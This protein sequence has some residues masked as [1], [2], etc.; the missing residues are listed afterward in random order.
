MVLLL[1]LL[2]PGSRIRTLALVV[3]SA[4]CVSS[5]ILLPLRTSLW[6][7][8]AFVRH[9]EQRRRCRCVSADGWY[10][11]LRSRHD[12]GCLLRRSGGYR[13]ADL[14]S[15]LAR[16]GEISAL[17][18]GGCAAEFR[19]EY[20]ADRACAEHDDLLVLSSGNRRLVRD[21]RICGR[22]AHPDCP[23]DWRSFACP[24]DYA[25]VARETPVLAHWA[26]RDPVSMERAMRAVI[27]PESLVYGP[28]AQYFLSV[29]C[30]WR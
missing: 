8:V 12:I 21:Y 25:R 13:R 6:G 9:G 28:K 30:D 20:A 2:I 11:G 23:R 19:R 7:F 18:V 15:T 27:P 5:L 10:L 26:E 22:A 24:Y 17:P 1:P 4:A 29:D 16:T 3:V 14:P